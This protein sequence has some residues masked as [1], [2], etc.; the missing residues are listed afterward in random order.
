MIRIKVP[1]TTSNLGVG[2]DTLGMALNIYNVFGFTETKEFH[3]IGF[4]TK[5][6]ESN[7]VVKTYKSFCIDNGVNEYDIKKVTIELLENGVPISRGL[8][9]SATCI[10]AGLLAANILN[11]LNKTME[12]CLIYASLLEGHPDNVFSAVKGG[13]NATFNHNG[14]FINETLEVSEKL[15]F[16]VLIPNNKGETEQLRNVLPTHA[17]LQDAV[18]NL[19]R[20]V[21]LPKAFKEGKLESLKMILTDHLHELYRAPFIPHYNQVKE[22][23]VENNMICLISGSGPTLFIIS[24]KAVTNEFKEVESTFKVI[25]VTQTS[26]TSWESVQ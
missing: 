20:I 12:E 14:I 21:Q 4:E 17:L 7:L 1:A 8:G 11:N 25:N 13:L 23:A 18:Y 6:V 3:L 19:S 9:S 22:I 10:I 2:F 15:H 5:D 16:T 26:G 24:S